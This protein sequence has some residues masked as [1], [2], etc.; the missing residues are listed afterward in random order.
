ML[1]VVSID[2]KDLISTSELAAHVSWT[3]GQDKRDENAFA[4]FATNDVKT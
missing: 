4:I 1:E 2:R 3:T